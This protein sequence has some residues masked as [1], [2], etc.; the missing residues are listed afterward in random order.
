M[1]LQKIKFHNSDSYAEIT[2]LWHKRWYASSITRWQKGK[3]AQQVLQNCDD[4]DKFRPII[5]ACYYTCVP[6]HSYADG[7]YSQSYIPLIDE[8]DDQIIKNLTYVAIDRNQFSGGFTENSDIHDISDFL[9]TY[10]H[11][12]RY[13]Y[14]D[15]LKQLDDIKDC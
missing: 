4:G 8:Q 5:L 2:N 14:C 15:C 13:C 12:C 6:E 3:T 1:T 10:S 7:I 11:G 9:T